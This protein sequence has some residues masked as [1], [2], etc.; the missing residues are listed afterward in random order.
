MTNTSELKGQIWRLPLFSMVAASSSQPSPCPFLWSSTEQPRKG[1]EQVK[2][3]NDLK[4]HQ[5]QRQIL[6]PRAGGL[7]WQILPR[8]R[9]EHKQEASRQKQ[10]STSSRQRPGNC[11]KE[12]GTRPQRYFYLESWSKTGTPKRGEAWNSQS[13]G[14]EEAHCPIS[15]RPSIQQETLH[16]SDPDQN[17]QAS[18]CG[19]R[20]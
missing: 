15:W 18:R 5:F 19:G 20:P 2:G 10:L 6:I 17:G 11:S 16:P 13:T 12:V 8:R 1:L 4:A 3:A 14:M 7:C 9:G